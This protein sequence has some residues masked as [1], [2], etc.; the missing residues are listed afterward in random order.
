VPGFAWAVFRRAE[1]GPAFWVVLNALVS[2]TASR[3]KRAVG[4]RW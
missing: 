1:G 2:V 4:L 3:L